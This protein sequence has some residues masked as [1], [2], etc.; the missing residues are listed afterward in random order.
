MGI[1]WTCADRLQG[2]VPF[3]FDGR[4]L[5]TLAIHTY[6]QG[7][8]PKVDWWI[9][10]YDVS[11]SQTRSSVLWD[12]LVMMQTGGAPPQWNSTNWDF[13]ALDWFGTPVNQGYISG[14]FRL[15]LQVVSGLNNTVEMPLVVMTGDCI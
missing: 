9:W 1:Y 14:V 2:T 10:Y 6:T 12:R 13:M 8:G 5:H 7:I 11:G 3:L 15:G 4:G